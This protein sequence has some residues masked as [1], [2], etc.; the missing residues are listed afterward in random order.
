MRSSQNRRRHAELLSRFSRLRNP[1][2]N[3]R[4]VKC[5]A[6]M[7]IFGGGGN[8]IEALNLLEQEIVRAEKAEARC[9]R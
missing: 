6:E 5:E 2:A 9:E 7:M 3:V 8:P 1:G 4:A